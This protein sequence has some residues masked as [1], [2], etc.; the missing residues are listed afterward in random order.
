MKD[1]ANRLV[2]KAIYRSDD[3]DYEGA[4]KL[5]NRAIKIDPANAQAYNERAMAQLNLNRDQEA[6]PD[7]GRALELNPRFPGARGWRARTLAKLGDHRGAA[8]EWLHILR[9]RTWSYGGT[10]VKPRQWADCAEQFAL[11]GDL[12]RAIAL[13]EKYLA[14]HATDA[15]FE[16]APL[17]VLAT[18]LIQAG[19]ADRAVDLAQ[20]AYARL[21]FFSEWLQRDHSGRRAT[22]S[23]LSPAG[24][25]S[26]RRQ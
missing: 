26:I 15:D 20:A 13:L 12:D 6:L 17:R 4:V 11:A 5:L 3:G 8:E 14:R 10:G 23:I 21:T 16:T 19:K 7:C 22:T 2:G 25:T 9:D 24:H 18:L 1:P